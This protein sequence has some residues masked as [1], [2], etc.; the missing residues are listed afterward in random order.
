MRR[1]QQAAQVPPL[2][3]KT[4]SWQSVIAKSLGLAPTNL[5][6]SLFDVDGEPLLERLSNLVRVARMHAK[7][8]LFQ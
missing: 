2:D 3:L 4:G 5:Y 8:I 6:E 1:R 7:E